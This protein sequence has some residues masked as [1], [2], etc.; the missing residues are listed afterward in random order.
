MLETKTIDYVDSGAQY[1]GQWLQGFR[2]GRGE[3]KFWDGSTYVG[4]WY[5][6]YACGYGKFTHA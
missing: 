1:T 3:I 4:D 6:G 5:L 2:H